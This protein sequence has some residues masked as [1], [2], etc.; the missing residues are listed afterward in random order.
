MLGSEDLCWAHVGDLKSA[1][2]LTFWTS[3]DD[4]IGSRCCDGSFS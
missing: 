4:G 1:I 2:V 3:G